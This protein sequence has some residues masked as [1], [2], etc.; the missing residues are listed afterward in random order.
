MRWA[1]IDMKAN[2]LGLTD[3]RYSQRRQKLGNARLIKGKRGRTI[4][5][6]PA[7]RLVLEEKQR[8]ADGLLFHGPRGGKVKPDVVRNILVREVITPLAARFPTATGEIGFEHGRVHSFRHFFVSEAFRLGVPEPRIMEWVGHRDSR[9]VA[10]YRHLRD[11]DGQQTMQGLD[12]I[13][14]ED[15]N[16][17]GPLT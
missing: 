13:G 7:F 10:R 9:I 11:D 14:K 12:F 6:N 15:S 1:D 4:P 3:E 17:S 16:R 2:V 8:S 5:L